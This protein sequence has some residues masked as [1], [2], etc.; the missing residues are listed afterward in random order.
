MNLIENVETAQARFVYTTANGRRTTVAYIYDDA[1]KCIRYGVAQ[2]SAKD[3]FEKRVGRDVAFGRLVKTGGA[4]VNYDSIA[5]T[6]YSTIAAYFSGLND[7]YKDA[8][9]GI[10]RL[11][12]A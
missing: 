1:A 10:V 11:A 8:S 5:D 4:T 6:K 3:Q 2:C 12:Y 9:D 7:A